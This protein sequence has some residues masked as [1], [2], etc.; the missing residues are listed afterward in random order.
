MKSNSAVADPPPVA[1]GRPLRFLMLNWRDPRNPLAGG[2]ERVTLAY[3]KGLIDRGHS[4]DW[5]TF[6]FAGAPPE[7]VIDGIRIHRG[8]GLGS[9][10]TRAMRWYRRQP[11]FDLVIDQHHGIPWFAPWW[12][13]THCL[14]YI[15]EVLG[16]IWSSFYRWPINAFGP[17]QERW[18]HWAYRKVPFWVPSESTR[19]ALIRHGVREV[20]VFD[21]GVDV[22]PLATLDPKPAAP[23]IRLVAVSRL[24]PNKRVDHAIRCVAVLRER[25]VGAELRVVGDGIESGRL[26][27]LVGEMG[28]EDAVR[29]VGYVR[30]QEKLE[31]LRGAH[32]LLHPSVR[33]GW[34]L[35]VIEA[36]AM[37]TPAVVY[38]VGG[39][40]DS[41][42]HGETGF[43]CAGERPEDLAEGVAW[44]MADLGRYERLR[45]AGWERSRGF[46]WEAVVP[47][48][49]SFLEAQGFGRK[50]V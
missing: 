35:N 6:D 40:V 49:C 21:N 50:M 47:P 12:C 36:N 42:R 48:V 8:G 26:R 38:P 30:E 39:L 34:G 7:E 41:T 3:L 28:V 20:R 13:R 37:G 46:R 18:T 24:A 17:W 33:E 16:P 2:A 15:H 31:E 22:E 11:R 10:I 23:P 14:G 19:Q 45:R 5:F 29:F 25:G 43:V 9:A 1:T 4:V 27:R 32:L 44:A